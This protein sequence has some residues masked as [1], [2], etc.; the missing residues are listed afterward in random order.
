M[1]SSKE[2]PLEFT[3]PHLLSG[4]DAD[5]PILAGFSGGADSTAMLYMLS[6][7]GRSTGAKIYAAHINHGIRGAEAD[8]D[9][10]FC[11]SLCDTLGIEL[12]VLKADVPKIAKDTGESIET[13]ARN[14]RYEFFENVMRE[15]DI[16]L[17]ATAHNA[18]DNLETMLFNMA[19]GTSLSG[20]CGIPETRPCEGGT[21]IRPILRMQKSDIL[22]FCNENGLEFVTDSTNA[23]TDYTRNKIRAE[24]IPALLEINSGAVKNAARLSKTLTA[25][26][27]C[28]ESMKNM[29]LEGL[30]DGCSVE[31][32]KLNGSPDAIVNRALLSLYSDIS[33]G[34]SLE[35]VHV[36]ALRRLSAEEVPHSSVTLPKGIEAVIEDRRLVF[37][38][39]VK[40]Q[41]IEAY[42]IPLSEGN[43]P[44]SQTNCEIVIVNSQNTKNIYKNSTLLS[45]DFAKINGSLFARSRLAGDKILMGGMHKSVKKL[46]CDKKIPLELRSRIPVIC[47]GNGIVAI[48]FVGI[49]DGARSKDKENTT[50][51]HFY[52]Y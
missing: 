41:D 18:N 25:D 2:L 15:N 21:V 12:F 1:I 50:C 42:S 46:M 52:M 37:R 27:L 39:I 45:I 29:F 20:M 7:Y 49:R 8:R 9:E 36:T 11:R 40:K 26:S 19:R 35:A 22:S 31:T 51:L 43:N 14:V 5:T 10:Q 13:A 38:R 28:L 17:L 23:D 32:E 44:I 34:E 48:P 6:V 24:I 3:P 16:S 30:S 33:G 4:L 47:D